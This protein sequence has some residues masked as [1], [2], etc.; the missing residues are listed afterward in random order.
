MAG[1]SFGCGRAVIPPRIDG[2]SLD[3]QERITRVPDWEKGWCIA[4]Q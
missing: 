3:I 1:S 4:V 2:P